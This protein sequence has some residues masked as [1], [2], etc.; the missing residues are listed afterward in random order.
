MNTP[1]GKAQEVKE[2]A[3]GI[4]RASTA[5]H[6]GYRISAERHHAMPDVL[7]AHEPYAG[8]HWYEEDCD[9]AVVALAFPDEFKPYDVFQ[10]VRMARFR[11]DY[12][13]AVRAWLDSG[14]AAT[15][16][17]LA[18][19]QQFLTEN[20]QR[21]EPGTSMTDGNGWRV[22]CSTLDGTRTKQWVFP[23]DTYYKL[24][25]PTFTEEDVQ[26]VIERHEQAKALGFNSIEQMEKHQ[27]WLAEQAGHT[28]R[29]RA[30][31]QHSKATG[32]PIDIRC[33]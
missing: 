20:G 13:K 11:Q 29:V 5:S 23:G 21:F 26:R 12:F 22:T 19:Y 30:A 7:R 16:R 33:A 15:A 28:E 10:A 18:I 14:H 6:G 27:V 4:T 8:R 9:W 17:P 1:W 32:E 3:D 24:P 31:V 2:I 25:F